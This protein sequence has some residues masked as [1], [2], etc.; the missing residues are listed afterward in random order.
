MGETIQIGTTRTQCISAYVARPDGVPKGGLVVVQ[1]I[2]GVN[3]HMRSVADRFAAQGYVAIAPAFFDHI[4]HGVALDYDPASWTRAREL[5]AATPFE[6]VLEDVASAAASIA[7][8]GKIGVVG[9]CWGGTVAML[10]AMRLGLPAVSYYGSRNVNFLHEPLHAAA[11]FHFGERDKSIPPEAIA[12]HRS[13]L[14]FADTMPAAQRELEIYT[15]PADHAFNRDATASSYDAA[16][17]AL[18]LERTLAFFARH[19]GDA[20]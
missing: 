1:E 4:E 8:S 17:A 10:S 18:A 5:V 11:I 19:L 6:R 16:S 12:R 15:Y 20:Q 9:Y 13:E 7:S 3:A 2:F 14:H